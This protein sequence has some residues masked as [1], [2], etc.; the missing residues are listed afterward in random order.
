VQTKEQIKKSIL[1]KNN[2]D[3]I[4]PYKVGDT[5]RIKVELG[6]GFEHPSNNVS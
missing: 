1:P 4:I 6:T 3:E 2:K 5:V